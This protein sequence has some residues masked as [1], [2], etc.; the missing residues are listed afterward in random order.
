MS[1]VTR[2]LWCGSLAA[3]TVLISPGSA[4][5]QD[6]LQFVRDGRKL[7]QAGKL[8]EAL[9]L[10]RQAVAADPKQFDAQ[11]ALGRALDLAGDLAGGRRALQQA[12]GL[13]PESGRDTVLAALAVSYAF[14]SRPVE[15]EKYYRQTFD[16]Q[17]AAGRF[18]DASATANAIGRVYLE[19]GDAANAE[20]WYRSGYD[21]A[22]K[23]ANPTLAQAD[24][25]EWRWLNAQGRIAARR[26]EFDDA[27]KL[28]AE[29]KAVLDKGTNDDQSAYYPYLV[30]YI[31]FYAKNYQKAIDELAKGDLRDVF[32]LGLIAQAH[33]RLGDRE[34]AREYFARV[35][36]SASHS[37][38][39]AFS[40]PVARAYLR[41]TALR[42]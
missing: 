25:L 21:T 28:A 36:A 31:E 3:C 38:N 14:E 35:M 4:L 23:L 6:A 19:A 32:V 16:R 29:G 9:A 8:D 40:R 1:T 17:L 20:K 13:A 7:E 15:S 42:P 22:K 24:V 27:R 2:L 12:L 26:G 11:F 10:Y 33:D 37:I 39:A 34:K 5:A 41:G 18:E 30:G